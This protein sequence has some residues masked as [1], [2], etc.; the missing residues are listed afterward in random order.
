MFKN[1]PKLVLFATL[2]GL[3]TL[4]NLVGCAGT[5]TASDAPAYGAGAPAQL[6][7]GLGSHHRAITTSEPEAQMYFDQGLN[8]MY[9]FNHDEAVRSFTRATAALSAAG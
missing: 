8:W 2:A 4:A 7:E 5:G 6:F 9:A 1:T 3:V